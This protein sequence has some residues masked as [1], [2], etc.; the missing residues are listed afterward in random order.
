MAIQND[1]DFKNALNALSVD[2]QRALAVSFTDSVIALCDDARVAG[3]VSAARRPDISDIE[4]AALY[5]AARTASVE[6]YTQCGKETD[7][8]IQAGHFV[9]NAAMACVAPASKQAN[10]AWD[11]AMQARMART[12]ET[13]SSGEGTTNREV[14]H[15]YRLLEQYQ[16]Q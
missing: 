8:A 5:Q 13:I 4:L 3:A 7:W 2:Q 10:L 6:S 11:A 9:A 14:D 15:Q 1:V 12:C 16:N